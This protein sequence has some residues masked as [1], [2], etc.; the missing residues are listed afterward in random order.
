MAPLRVSESLNTLGQWGAY[1]ALLV[2][3]AENKRR[4]MSE[5]S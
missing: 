2:W 4:V 3:R 1:A 5:R